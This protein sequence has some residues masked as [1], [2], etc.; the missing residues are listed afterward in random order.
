M[1]KTAARTTH[2]KE[3]RPEDKVKNIG[4]L[5]KDHGEIDIVTANDT[6]VLWKRLEHCTAGRMQIA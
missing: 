4:I 3:T 2:D 6:Y 5:N 1:L